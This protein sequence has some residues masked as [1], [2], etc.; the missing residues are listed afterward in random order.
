MK[1]STPSCPSLLKPFYVALCT[2][3]GHNLNLSCF[4]RQCRGLDKDPACHTFRSV[5]I[6]GVNS[7]SLK[8][9]PRLGLKSVLTQ[10]LT[11]KS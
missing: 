6:G 9:N 1:R 2:S 3:I 8:V 10:G 7:F 11:P 5:L 4:C